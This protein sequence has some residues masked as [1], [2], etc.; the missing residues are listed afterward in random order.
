MRPSVPRGTLLRCRRAF[1]SGATGDALWEHASARGWRV[2]ALIQNTTPRRATPWTR[3]SIRRSGGAQGAV[4]D[5]TPQ[6]ARTHAWEARRRA[7]QH[8]PQLDQQGAPLRLCFTGGRS[9]PCEM[10]FN[11]VNARTRRGLVAREMNPIISTL[12]AAARTAVIPDAG[13]S[14]ASPVADVPVWSTLVVYD[15]LCT[16]V[17][18]QEVGAPCRGWN[19]PPQLPR[20]RRLTNNAPPAAS[21]VRTGLKRARCVRDAEGRGSRI[22]G[23]R[24][25]RRV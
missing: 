25:P 14:G 17:D 4:H 7:R 13:A 10:H 2:S 20:I 19:S 21:A 22:S 18:A 24:V 16:S 15:A 12:V 3:C 11:R 5:T 8:S 23:T 9:A 6:P 1:D